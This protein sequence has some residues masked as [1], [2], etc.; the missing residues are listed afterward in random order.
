MKQNVT[1]DGMIESMHEVDIYFR[2][3]DYI[4]VPKVT[5]PKACVVKRIFN[6]LS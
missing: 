6:P 5:S 2:W 4:Q 1:S 3:V